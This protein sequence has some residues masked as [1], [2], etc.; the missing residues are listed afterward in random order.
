VS[1]TAASAAAFTGLIDLAAFGLGGKVLGASD[2]FFASAN[3]LI[4]PGRGI[5]VEGKFTDR[6]KWM[7][8]W[9]SRRK[10]GPGY[11]WCVLELG[12]PG[13]VVGFDVDTHFFVGNSPAFVSIEGVHAPRGTSL[14][15]L[16][17]MEW[18]ELLPQMPVRPDA[19]NLFA[20]TPGSSTTHVRLNIFPDGGVARFRVFGRVAAEWTAPALDRET[21]AHAIEGSVDLAAVTS[22]GLALACSDAFFGP[23]NNLLLPG[24]AENMGGGWETRRKRAPG[25]DWIVIQLGARGTINTIEVDTHH[26]KGNFPDRCSLEGIDAS[27]A[28]ITDLMASVAWVPLLPEVKLAADNRRFFTTDI[29]AHAAVSHVRLNIF[30]DGGVSRLRLWGTRAPEP[31]VLLNALSIDEARA[32]LLRCCGATRWV[33]WLLTQRPF[34]STDA[35]FKAAA[36]VWTQME[37]ADMLEAFSHHPEIGSDIA[38]L[39]QRFAS[40]AAWSSAEQAGV[41]GADD[42]TLEA[43]REG[44]VRYREKFGYVFL[45]CATGKTAAEM[46]ALLRVRL[47]HDPDT[48]LRVAAAEQGKITRLRL[49]KI[50]S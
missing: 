8:G 19:Q 7:D 17:A 45:V 31:H 1:E 50:S 4:E 15:A 34:A 44:N 33:G 35:L 38:S 39:R 37:K 24:R 36:G 46:L 42:A 27:S 26:F 5:F 49:E 3:N 48:E 18:T 14:T 40:T 29:A 28:R 20:A 11:D 23:M 22:G 32:A 9:E 41:A 2:D 47:A 25:H 16:Q 10:R 43:L 12:A 6:G 21:R 13:T 30:P